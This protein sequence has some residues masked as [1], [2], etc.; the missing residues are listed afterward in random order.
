MTQM[1]VE[2][3]QALQEAGT[4]EE[5]AR[6]AASQVV[7]LETLATK[8]DIL[9]IKSEIV[10]LDGEIVRLDG[11]ID[12]LDR[13]IDRLAGKLDGKIDKLDR[14][15]D[16]LAGK[17]DGKIDKLESSVKSSLSYWLLWFGVGLVALMLGGFGT[18][19]FLVINRV[20]G[21]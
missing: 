18:L 19:V 9:E 5:L 10:R 16:R 15:I 21:A 12:K 8:A 13:K 17:L 2:T 6:A 7:P 1:N 3:Y 4:S 20:G 11:K 14:K